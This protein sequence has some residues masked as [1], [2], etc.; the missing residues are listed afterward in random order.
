MTWQQ[1]V[2]ASYFTLTCLAELFLELS[3]DVLGDYWLVTDVTGCCVN[4]QLFLF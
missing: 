3:V 1:Q 4:V 2:V